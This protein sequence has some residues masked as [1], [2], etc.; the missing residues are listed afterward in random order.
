MRN[1][2]SDTVDA[3]A[4][5]LSREPVPTAEIEAALASLA[6][7]GYA[8]GFEPGRWRAT[9]QGQVASEALLGERYREGMGVAVQIGGRS[10][11]AEFVSQGE[12]DEARHDPH[13]DA[14]RDVA[15]VKYL[16]GDAEG[17]L[18]THFYR[19]IDIL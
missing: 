3:I 7:D 10:V 17:T 11:R 14:V 8:E 13:V 2:E 15:W 1:H 16:E 9:P 18:G 12:P 5:E 19:E 6:A 4:V